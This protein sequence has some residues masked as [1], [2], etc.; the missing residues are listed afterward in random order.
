MLMPPSSSTRLCAYRS[1]AS[2]SSAASTTNS[3]ATSHSARF[4][5]TWLREIVPCDQ[6]VLL[7][8]AH[9]GPA[10]HLVKL[11]RGDARS[12]ALGPH[13]SGVDRGPRGDVANRHDAVQRHVADI[14]LAGLDHL[15]RAACLF[16]GANSADEIRELRRLHRALLVG[17]RQR[18]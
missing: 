15:G 6:P 8:G 11:P 9:R 1:R 7:D 12:G 3:H 13:V 14:L 18:A 10:D 4:I 17:T 2:V 16:D 5:W